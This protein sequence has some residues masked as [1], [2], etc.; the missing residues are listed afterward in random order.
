M[1]CALCLGGVSEVLDFGDVALA[2]AF[3][4][5]DQFAD[6]KRYPLRLAYCE[7]CL[8]LQVV[9]RVDPKAMFSTYFYRSS[10]IGTLREHFKRLADEI[11]TTFKPRKLVEIGCNDGV[12]LRH[13]AG[14]VPLLFG[15]DPSN[16]LQKV[17]GACVINEFFTANVAHAIGSADVVVAC[18]V[19]AHI[20]D[21]DGVTEAVSN[22]LAD[23]GVFI[24]EVNKLDS[25]I[26]SLQY[27]WIYHEH[28]YYWS[29]LSLQRMLKRH[30]LEV[31]DVKTLSNHAGSMRCYIG[32]DG[33]RQPTKA[34]QQHMEMDIW[35]GLDKVERFK[36]FAADAENHREA[37]L[38]LVDK[39]YP[40]AGYGACGR[41]NTLIQFCGIGPERMPYIIDDAPTKHGYYTPGSHIPIVSRESV[42]GKPSPRAL[43]VFAWSFLSEIEPK[44]A[45]YPGRVFV[46]LPHIYEHKRKAAA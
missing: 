19:F 16:A 46:P 28:L 9:D 7:R 40:V 29:M 11:V 26:Y 22:M 18:N 33:K 43:I 20:E 6:E 8:L 3:L 13:L 12:L 34:V 36:R 35:M 31:F 21:I 2:G 23:D 44:L 1:R 10:E 5:K 24:L 27:D 14:R 37:L 15:V 41:A 4:T 42:M 32:K 30:G 39:H 45:G 38:E 17:T 25:L